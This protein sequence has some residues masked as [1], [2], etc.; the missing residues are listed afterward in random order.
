LL[1]AGR[2]IISRIDLAAV[3]VAGV[4]AAG[5]DDLLR[6]LQRRVDVAMR[7]L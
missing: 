2:R 7:A 1:L 3:V 5:H 6:I 4:L